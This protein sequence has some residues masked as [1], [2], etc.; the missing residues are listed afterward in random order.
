MMTIVADA[1][2]SRMIVDE[3]KLYMLVVVGA[4]NMMGRKAN[5]K[6]SNFLLILLSSGPL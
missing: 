1:A 4:A 6:A 5:S 3:L 2:T